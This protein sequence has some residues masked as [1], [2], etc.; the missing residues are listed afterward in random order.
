LNLFQ[1]HTGRQKM[2]FWHTFWWIYVKG[3]AAALLSPL[4]PLYLWCFRPPKSRRTL[5]A[6]WLAIHH[7]ASQDSLQFPVPRYTECGGGGSSVGTVLSLF[8]SGDRWRHAILGY[9][10][11]LQLSITHLAN[12]G[13]GKFTPRENEVKISWPV[14]FGD[15]PDPGSIRVKVCM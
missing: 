1:L 4:L 8:L 9:L 6:L 13:R 11:K 7:C 10:P 12:T 14:I 3:Q 2:M 15:F 5:D